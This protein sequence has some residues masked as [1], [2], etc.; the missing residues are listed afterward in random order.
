MKESHPVH[1]LYAEETIYSARQ[2]RLIRGLE[3]RCANVISRVE[4]L[5][6]CDDKEA[7]LVNCEAERVH[8]ALLG[9][10]IQIQERRDKLEYKLRSKRKL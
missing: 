8:W 6:D 7:L 2:L 1:L 9:G 10:R 5:P 3:K 4:R